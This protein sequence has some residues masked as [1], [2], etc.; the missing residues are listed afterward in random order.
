[1]IKEITSSEANKMLRKLED[2]KNYILEIENKSST[3]IVTEGV[4]NTPVPEYNYEKSILKLDEIDCKVV[5]I[6]HALNQFNCT[7]KLPE[8][9][10]T[11][12]QALIKMAQL[13]KKKRRLDIMRKRLPKA[14]KN[15]RYGNTH[16]VEYEYIN[17]DLDKV[18]ADY[19]NVIE[20]I[21]TLQMGI[22]FCNQTIKFSIDL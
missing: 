3:Y 7:T 11:I 2:D 9:N 13:T 15:D 12:D 20:Q 1:M 16:V 8:S 17:Y 21:A 5:T 19:E 14:R 18:N 6:K 4:K 22:D 10:L